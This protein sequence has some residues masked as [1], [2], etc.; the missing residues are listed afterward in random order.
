MSKY[1]NTFNEMYWVK[2]DYGIKIEVEAS[3]GDR[4]E[5]DEDLIDDILDLFHEVNRLSKAKK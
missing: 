5:I 3:D 1:P 4:Q 2:G